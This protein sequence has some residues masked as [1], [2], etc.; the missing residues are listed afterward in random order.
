[1]PSIPQLVFLSYSHDSRAHMDRVLE[2]ADRLRRDG[3]DA[4]LD[5]YEPS[6]AE[7]WPRWSIDRVKEADFVLVV[8]TETYRRRFDG[9]AA[10]GEG[11][12]VTWEGATIR[13]RLY[14]R[15]GRNDKFLP[16]V[17]RAADRDH[18]PQIL[19]GPTIHDLSAEDGYEDLYRLLTGQPATPRPELGSRRRLP[20]R[21][22]HRDFPLVAEHG[23]DRG[24]L[25]AARQQYLRAMWSE[26]H[27]LQLTGI[28]GGSSERR[29]IPLAAVYTALDV[30]ETIGVGG[31]GGKGLAREGDVWVTGLIED[32]AY[33]EA[34]RQRLRE[35]AEAQRED[36]PAA[37]EGEGYRRPLTALEAA[38]G[39]P[40]LVL[41]GPA[42]SGKSTFARYLA[43]SLAGEALGRDEANLRRLNGVAEGAEP[44]PRV[45]WPHGPLLPIFVE[46][47]R[48]VGSEL[49]ATAGDA[50]ADELL[51]FIAA[52]APEAARPGFWRLLEEAL[53][54]RGPGALLVLDG[55]DETPAAERSRERLRR[56]IASFCARYPRCRVLV[57]CRPYAYDKGSPWRLDD[58]GFGEAVLAPFDGAKIGAFIAAWYRQLAARRQVRRELAKQRSEALRR[59]IAATEYLKPLAERPL[60]LTMMADLHATGG[61]RLPGGR[62]GLYER[63]VELLLDRW[64]QLR[65][66]L[67][68]ETLA[69]HLGMTVREMRGALEKL[70]YEVHRARGAEDGGPAGIS[71]GELWRALDGGRRPPAEC[72]VDEARVMEYLHQRSGILLGESPVLYRFPHRSYQEYLAACHL[73]RVGFPGLLLE[74]VKAGPGLWR[75]VLLLAVGKV[76]A[77]PFTAWAVLEGLVPEVPEAGV[78]AAGR[79][80][81]LALLAGLAVREN[82]LW[83][84]VQE[85]DRRKLERVRG[86]LERCLEV[87]ALAPVDRAAAGQ[88]LGLLGDRRPGV[89]VGEDGIPEIDWVEVEAG[90]FRMGDGRRNLV[91]LPAFRIARFPV[92]NVQYRA[93]VA[94]GGYT[95]AWR[96]CWADESWAWM[97]GRAGPDDDLGEVFLLDNHPRVNVCWYEADAFCRWLGLK[98]GYEVRLPAEEQWEKAARGTDGRTYPWGE[99]FDPSRCNG[100]KTGIGATTAV[101]AFPNGASPCGA[102]D[103]SGNV[104]EWCAGEIELSWAKGEPGRV[105]R[106]GGWNHAVEGLR[107]ASRFRNPAANRWVDYGFRVSAPHPRPLSQPPSTPAQG[108][109]RPLPPPDRHDDR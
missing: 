40:R 10:P 109:G 107:A 38:A 36:R 23:D 69:E 93:F 83:R 81:A 102:L 58:Q 70:A 71:R 9:E 29:D 52:E 37:P 7:G 16:V 88:V 2:L 25:E 92:T 59:E 94:D 60:M 106:G 97:W 63:S 79:R 50:G 96:Q 61:G 3:V 24:A 99:D 32:G 41:L 46:L 21:R 104:W 18:V 11:K 72:R 105:L 48:L 39:V 47:R 30:N 53:L 74:E 68:R 62:A 80:F 49:F 6:P 51:A 90:R 20:P 56:V 73:T 91:D 64:N 57:T 75:E 65:E 12:G 95:D 86:W 19:R 85:Q 45:A 31:P 8:C 15:Q 82:D 26:C 22:R 13:Q 5:Q 108:E 84:D 17:L 67:G 100:D 42:G 78:E 77:T 34:L 1:M 54:D 14:D 101:G 43:L 103:M 98:L 27:P 89:G 4:D 33:L 55:L 28:S 44:P 76:A 35:E 87:G 66:V